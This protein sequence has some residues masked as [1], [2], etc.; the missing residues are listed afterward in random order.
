MKEQ[1]HTYA[2]KWLK[3]FFAAALC[4]LI[5]VAVW[6]VKAVDAMEETFHVKDLSTGDFSYSFYLTILAGCLNVLA[7]VLFFNARREVAA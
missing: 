1:A 5:E 6:A 7:T 2:N 3:P 4:A